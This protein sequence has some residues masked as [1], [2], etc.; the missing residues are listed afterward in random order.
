MLIHRYVYQKN[1]GKKK[2]ARKKKKVGRR[3][4][5]MNNFWGKRGSKKW[6]IKDTKTAF[7]ILFHPSLPSFSSYHFFLFSPS[8]SLSLIHPL[9]FSLS[10]SLSL[11]IFPCASP[12]CVSIDEQQSRIRNGFVRIWLFKTCILLS[13][14]FSMH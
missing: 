12:G 7:L 3:K 2:G 4:K 10:L 1:E 8:C 13:L 9:S 6:R 11:S 14:L 5:K